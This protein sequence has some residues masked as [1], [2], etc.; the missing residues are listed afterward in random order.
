MPTRDCSEP[1][2]LRS[3]RS[4]LTKEAEKESVSVFRSNLRQ[5]LL[6]P[7]VRGHAVLGIDPGFKHGCKLAAV[8]ANGSLL[9]HAV[10]YPH[11]GNKGPAANILRQMVLTHK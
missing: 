1:H 9:Q 8:S 10:I 11:S 5:L 4:Q 6:T 3:I 2:L 7:P